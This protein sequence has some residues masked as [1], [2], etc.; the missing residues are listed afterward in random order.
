MTYTIA[1]Y[2]LW[3]LLCIPVFVLGV[4]LC[5]DLMNGIIQEN[6]EKKAKRDA[7]SA[8]ERSRLDFEEEYRRSRD[9]SLK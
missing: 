4:G 7:K 6:R 3:I 2:A 9:G 5:G 8:R 1:R